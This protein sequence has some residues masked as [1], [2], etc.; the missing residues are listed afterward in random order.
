MYK[1]AIC[2]DDKNYI[3]YLKKIIMKAGIT[4]KDAVLFYEFYSGEQLLFQEE[5]DFDLIIMDMQMKNLDGYE[6]AMKLKERGFNFLLVFCSG[7]VQPSPKSFK[8]APY[9]YLMKNYTDEEMI[10]EMQAI[11]KEMVSRKKNL[12]IMCKYGTGK[13]QIR[14]SA[15]D[16]L[17]IAIRNVGTQIFPYGELKE[18]YPDEMLRSNMDLNTI[19]KVFDEKNG[20]VRAHNSYIINM[21]YV[22]EMSPGIVKMA[23]G[24]QLTVSRARSKEFQSEFAK[25]MAAKYE[26]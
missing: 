22:V 12:Y 19:S 11:L 13:G 3:N 5:Q 17:Y 9:R 25:F 6:T 7:V 4:E 20:F 26:E 16:I 24:T 2:E 21:A 15:R 8:A 1:I 18:I 14:V 10:V 23:D